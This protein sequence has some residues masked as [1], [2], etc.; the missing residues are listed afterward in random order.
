M[1]VYYEHI[2]EIRKTPRDIA[3]LIILWLLVVGFCVAAFLFIGVFNPLFILLCLAA[4]YGG[5]M[6]TK[7]LNVEFEYIFTNGEIDIDMITAK[8]ER[9]RMETF[10]VKDIVRVEKY[11]RENPLSRRENIE[12]ANVYCNKD[13]NDLYTLLIKRRNEEFCVTLQL[14]E[15]FREKILPFMDKIIARDAFK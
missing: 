14:N 6:L 2:T 9:K 1:D 12:K 11:N 5:I 3:F 7:K 10:N 15:T 8:S 4:F 13:D